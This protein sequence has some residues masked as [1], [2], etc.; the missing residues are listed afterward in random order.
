MFPVY[1]KETSVKQNF[2]EA[3]AFAQPQLYLEISIAKDLVV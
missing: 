2:K 1:Q 3:F